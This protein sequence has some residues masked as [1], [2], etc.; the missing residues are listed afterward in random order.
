MPTSVHVD[1]LKINKLTE[2]QYDAA[3][4]AG[5]IGENELSILTDAASGGQTIQYDTMPTASASNEGD[6]VQFVGTSDA[7][8][9]NGYFYQCVSDGAV[10]P[11]YSWVAKEVQVA[12]DSLPSQSGNSGKFLTTDGTNASWSDKP[13]ANNSTW[14][15]SSISV[16]GTPAGQ[17]STVSI[18]IG[19]NPGNNY[20]VTLIGSNAT[21]HY[22]GCICIGDNA[23]YAASAGQTICIGQQANASS[24][25]AIQIGSGTNSEA[26]TLQIGLRTQYGTIPTQYKLLDADGTIPEARLADTTNATQ[27]QVLTL[28]SNNNAVWATPSASVS[29]V[30]GTLL[31]GSTAWGSGT[32]TQTLAVQGVT[33]SNTVIVSPTPLSS[34][35][36]ADAGIIC[37]AQSTNQLTFTCVTVPTNDIELSIVI[38]G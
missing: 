30:S 16:G 20:A 2:A 13:L 11:T 8:Y 7:N 31:S 4:Q 33:S 17:Q 36:Y 38:I 34:T 12:G 22:A 1:E 29:T 32:D 24:V 9:T 19:S 27:G 21:A 14:A 37:T 15:S 23:G 28:D 35:D 6:I 5:L 3:V 25:G 10:T 18:G 26:G